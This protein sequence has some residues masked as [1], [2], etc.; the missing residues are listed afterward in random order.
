MRQTGFNFQ[1]VITKN[2]NNY[3][4]A[5]DKDFIKSALQTNPIIAV[6]GDS[7]VEA[8]QVKN[9]DTFHAILDANL[10]SYD[11]Y[12]IGM[13]GSPLSQY[14]AFSKYMTEKFNP[15]L[16]VFLIIANDFD[17]SF[18]ETRGKLGFHYFD[19]FNGLKLVNYEPSFVK[20]IGR[21]S[22]FLRYL[23]LDLKLTTQFQNIFS[24]E[25][26]TDKKSKRMKFFIEKGRIAIDRFLEGIAKISSTS[27]VIIL[28]DGDRKA[29]YSGLEKKDI[30]N[31]ANLLFK[32]LE[33]FAKK[34]TNVDVV[35]LH[36][37]FKDDWESNKK[38]FNYD[39]DYHCNE[40]GHALAAKV[41][42]DKIKELGF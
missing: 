9:K 20:L 41:L 40:H 25:D 2:I 16:Y 22:A 38:K 5:T 28:L 29:I 31:P 13:S 26:I 37:I 15:K 32:E 1:H 33:G 14:L 30:N 6:I 42:T 4:Y 34:I 27:N 12:P 24:K 10:D 3:G 35:D 8:L 7:Y 23:H 39:Y 18:F 11:V 21:K 19:E 17:E 36:N